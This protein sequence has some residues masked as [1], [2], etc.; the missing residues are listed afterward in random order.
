MALLF[1]PLWVLQFEF[2]KQTWMV[3]GFKAHGPCKGLHID[4]W[5]LGSSPHRSGPG[6]H[7]DLL[8]FLIAWV[9]WRLI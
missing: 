8:T 3:L 6:L 4:A 1:E 9:V 2:E 5:I 7:Q